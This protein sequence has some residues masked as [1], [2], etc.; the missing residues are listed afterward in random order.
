MLNISSRK[1]LRSASPVNEPPG[2][3][4]I[5]LS[6]TRRDLAGAGHLQAV[7]GPRGH[8]LH[9][10]GRAVRLPQALPELRRDHQATVAV[11]ARQRVCRRHQ[12]ERNQRGHKIA[13][14][15]ERGV[16][17]N[18]DAAVAISAACRLIR[19]CPQREHTVSKTGQAGVS[20]G[21]YRV[22]GLDRGSKQGDR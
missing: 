13:K 8:P 16:G 18:H 7:H 19:R 2:C 12:R 15:G 22:G 11:S 5:C 3:L 14:T 17:R 10:R 6:A 4:S 9:H 20:V 1:T 21:M